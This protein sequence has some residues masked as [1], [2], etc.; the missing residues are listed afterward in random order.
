[1]RLL[2]LCVL[3]AFCGESAADKPLPPAEAAAR[4]TLP[5]GFKATLFAGEPD[6]VQP[7]A[8]T[9][10]DRGRL[11]VVEN[12]SYPNWAKDGTGRDRVLIF[13]DT[14]GD[15]RFDKRTVVIE[16]GSNLSGIEYGFGGIYLCSAPNL[17]HIPIK[18]DKPAGPPKV[19]LD[20]WTLEAIHN[21]FN[22]LAWGPDGWLYGCNGIT[23]TSYIG[24]PGTPE[25]ERTPFNCGV[26]RYHPTRHVF[27]P[28]AWG[29]TNP[30]GI[31]WNEDG[32]LFAT[33]CVIKHLF[34]VVP[35]GHYD[36]MFGQDL[37][38]HV[39]RL[40]ESCA[41]H[42]HWGGGHWTSARQKADGSVKT[43]H[44]DAGGGHA[45]V[46]C[47]VYLGDNWPA[48]YR[49]NVFMCNLHGNRVNR[50]ILERKGSGYVAKHGKDFLFANDPWF[51]GLALKYG[52]DG[53]VFVS[54]WTDTGE[55]HNYTGADQ[56]NGRIFKV[57]YGTPKPWTG[58]LARLSDEDLMKLQGHTNEWFVRHARRLLQERAAHGN[59][60]VIG[61]PGVRAAF[62][63]LKTERPLKALWAIPWLGTGYEFADYLRSDS[64]VVRAWAI[65][66][67][68]DESLVRRH[69]GDRIAEALRGETSPAVWRAAVSVLS[70]LP[71]GDSM[72][73]VKAAVARAELADDP[74]YP[75]VVW[76]SL[77]PLIDEAFDIRLV[78]RGS[79]P[80]VREACARRV[81]EMTRGPERLLTLFVEEDD[82]EKHRDL[83]AGLLANLGDRR[84]APMPAGWSAAQARALASPSGE[85]R[86]LGRRLAVLF[87][88]GA[89]ITELNRQASDRSARATDREE[90]F[91]LFAMKQTADLGAIARPLVTDPVLR[92]RALRALAN[93]RNL[94]PT[95]ILPHF[96]T[97]TDS[98]KSDA[99]A[100]L[101]TRPYLAAALLD[102]VESGAIPRKDVSSFTVRQL[103]KLKDA[104]LAERVKRVWGEARPASQAKAKLMAEYKN[105]LTP[106]VLAKADLARGKA[107]FTHHC[108]SCHKLHGEGG[109]IGP[110]LTGSQRA[111]LDY[112]LENTLDPS[113]VVAKEYQV[114]DVLTKA[115]RLVS[116]IVVAETER[117]VTLQTPTERVVVTL[118]E[119]DT[120]EQSKV[121]MMPEGIL[122]K[123]TR[124]ERRD[125][126]AYLAK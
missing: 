95:D 37:N 112:V 22:G 74:L 7:I 58:D 27:E 10:D 39:Y 96:A 35:G 23:K 116:G 4:M 31:D 107:L 102:A 104:K 67:Y 47:M 26:W 60:A 83:L 28:F 103:G 120:R 68:A 82:P 40:M 52:P 69:T 115:G 25:K 101:A 19:L 33:N 110:E 48:E 16:N 108:S 49:G 91:D 90:A 81:A 51:R 94:R 125:L 87:E 45:H 9:F 34:H 71:S 3:C 73:L 98:E 36:R 14:D 8:F 55:C 59:G 86:R 118:G 6:L 79:L 89:L 99:I 1:M 62:E 84:K 32:E 106:D 63:K 30:W 46:G 70:H 93:D 109:A 61:Q 20:G 114:T 75:L 13:E 53:G 24:K 97:F 29:M 88:D 50:D 122:E 64:P 126:V 66:L 80:F 77:E 105:E 38:P 42:I 92:G 18:D 76:Y 119:I 85:V 117:A 44:D 65:R 124:D 56:S 72:E 11:W 100:T 2:S 17:I 15:G 57:T 12:H 78:L 111:N 43:E 5:P 41:D 113:A 21:V 123:L 54:D 121:S